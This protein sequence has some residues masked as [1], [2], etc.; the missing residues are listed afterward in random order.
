VEV[1][2]KVVPKAA[3]S[4]L[5]PFL[6]ER[7]RPGLE[8]RL[9]PAAGRYVYPEPL[10]EGIRGVVHVCAGSGAAPNR[11]LIRCALGRGWPLRHLL[12]LQD[13]LPQDVLYRGEWP[14]L[15]ARY[16]D[17]FRL[18]V[19]LSSRGEYVDAADLAVALGGWLEPTAVLAFVCG[20][21]Y[22]RASAPGFVDLARRELA[23][24]GIPP[25]RIRWE[26]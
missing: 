16:P 23:A 9:G 15:E 4:P 26:Q 8:I 10:P 20:P 1:T 19:R 21:N 5:P 7:A 24:A 25:D 14:D 11:G 18:R 22:P 6:L 17:R 13:R 3:G 12:V 2:V